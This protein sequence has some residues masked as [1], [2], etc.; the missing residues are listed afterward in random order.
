M[1]FRNILLS[2]TDLFLRNDPCRKPRIN[3]YLR[4]HS[5]VKLQLGCS[6]H[7]LPDWLNTDISLR[8]CL[9]GSVYM[10]ASKR[11][12]LPDNSVD[13]IYTE[14]MIEHLNYN[15]VHSMLSECFRVMK[16]GGVLRIATPNY[17]FL[18]DLYKHPGKEINRKY[19]EWAAEKGNIPAMPILVINRFHTSWGHQII[20]D[21]DSLAAL[22][23]ESGFTNVCECKMS[24]SEHE[25]LNNVERHFQ[26]MPY[27]LCCLETMILEAKK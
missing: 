14:H 21:K 8:G 10:D 16:K 27:D 18:D 15:Q 9:A 6:R 7:F 25:P 24:I 20:Y 3:R 22:L 5:I 23:K 19:I 1:F 17:L 2:I 11:F 13:Y 26:T 4:N 12:L